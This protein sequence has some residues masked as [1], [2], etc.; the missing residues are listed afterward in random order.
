MAKLGRANEIVIRD[1]VRS[2]ERLPARHELVAPFL[3]SLARGGGGAGDFLAVFVGP[4]Q[5]ERGAKRASGARQYVRNEGRVSMADMRLAA[6]IVDR[7]RDVIGALHSSGVPYCRS[8]IGLLR[9]AFRAE[10]RA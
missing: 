4:R 6:D 8:L 1:V 5:E 2:E 10:M 7:R 3:R 9:R